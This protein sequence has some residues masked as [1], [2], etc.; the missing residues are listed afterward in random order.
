MFVY[1]FLGFVRGF[2]GC[3]TPNY[4]FDPENCHISSAKPDSWQDLCVNLGEG[5]NLLSSVVSAYKL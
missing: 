1:Y 2:A 4:Q 3:P 5:T